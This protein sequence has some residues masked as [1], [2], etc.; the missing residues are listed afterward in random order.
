MLM[1]KI[2]YI[3]ELGPYNRDCPVKL[4]LIHT[5]I[6]SQYFIISRVCEKKPI[7]LQKNSSCRDS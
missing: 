4:A 7:Q 2:Y 6:Y 1:V 5:K 3:K